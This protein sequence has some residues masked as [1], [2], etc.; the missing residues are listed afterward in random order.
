MSPETIKLNLD[1]AHLRSLVSDIG[2]PQNDI[3]RKLGLQKRQLRRYLG[4]PQSQSY[5]PMP[6]VVYYALNVWAAY[7]RYE[8]RQKQQLTIEPSD[9]DGE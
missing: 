8:R 5:E 9:S 2:L 1:F 4:N 6:Y 7:C 3:A